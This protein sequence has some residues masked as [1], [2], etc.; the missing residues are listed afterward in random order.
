MNYKLIYI[1][2]HKKISYS[3]NYISYFIIALYYI[4]WNINN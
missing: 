3:V 2:L 4:I 1:T